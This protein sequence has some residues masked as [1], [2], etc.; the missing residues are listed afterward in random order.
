MQ[1]PVVAVAE[2]DHEDPDEPN[3][4]SDVGVLVYTHGFPGHHE[5]EDHGRVA[6]IEKMLEKQFKTPS[7]IVLHMPYDWDEG[8]MKLD[9]NDVEYAIFLY[10]DM[11][12]P[13]STVI[14][15]VSRGVFGGIE[16]YNMCPG[17][18]AGDGCQYM[19]QLTEPASKVSDTILVFAEP[20][21]PDHPILR[22]IFVK[23]AKAVS[24]NPG[25][26]ILVLVGHGARSNFND[27][28]QEAELSNA[29]AFVKK[30]MGFADSIGVTAREDWPDLKPIAVQEAVDEIKSMLE[31]TGATK[32][33]LVP[34][35]G[36]SGFDLISEA[37]EAESVNFVQAPEPFPIG[38][39][40]FIKWADR[41]VK[42]TIKFINDEKPTESTITPYWDRDYYYKEVRKD[43]L[44]DATNDD[45]NFDIG[46][47][48]IND[49]GNP[50]LRVKGRGG[51]T[52]PEGHGTIYGY[53]FVTNAG[54]YAVTS[55]LGNDTP[56]EEHEDKKWHAHK[57]VLDENSC[58]SSITPDG[59]SR[60]VNKTVIMLETPATSLSKV[61]TVELTE[62]DDT[63]CV[64][65]V[66]DQGN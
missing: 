57:V 16:E 41:T 18:P 53:V 27:D 46:L 47:F 50:Y 29:A 23:Q 61:M 1:L 65:E 28:A 21:R 14:H 58:V 55:H 38:Q 31:E 3:F 45:P 49:D 10:T 60:I 25:D 37:L 4:S 24:E 59:E 36:A 40:E 33:V 32:V 52:V 39:R 12:G 20:A 42:E 26:E 19:G 9:E 7:E 56:G 62:Q 30:K 43:N 54:T 17:I 48:G 51:G 11:F 63:T 13:D 15:N 35:T 66:F 2:D 5:S 44:N 22:N 8:L 6:G 34:A 64:T